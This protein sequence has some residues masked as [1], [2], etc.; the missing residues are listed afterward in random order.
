MDVLFKSPCLILL[1]CFVYYE[2]CVH[3]VKKR[4]IDFDGHDEMTKIWEGIR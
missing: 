4:N 2:C 3:C 1:L